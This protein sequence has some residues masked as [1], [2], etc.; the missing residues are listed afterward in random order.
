[1]ASD[2]KDK[3]VINLAD[4]KRR[5][6][7]AQKAPPKAGASRGNGRDDGYDRAMRAQRKKSGIT[8][9]DGTVRWYHYLQLLLLLGLVAW[10]M[11]SCQG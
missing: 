4:A 6:T 1:M 3:N 2:Q 5:Q 10:L 7:T 11:R 9:G 8:G